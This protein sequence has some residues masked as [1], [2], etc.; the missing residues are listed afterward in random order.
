MRAEA[1]HCPQDGGFIGKCGCT[2]RNHEHSELVKGLL[3][4]A[5]TPH[6]ISV[7]DADAALEEGF[8]VTSKEGVRVGFGTPLKEHIELPSHS[9]SDQ[10][11]RK[12]CLLF[13][14]DTVQTTEPEE[15]D[16]QNRKGRNRYIKMM[17]AK[18]AMFVVTDKDGN[19]DFAKTIIPRPPAKKRAPAVDGHFG[20]DGIPSTPR[21]AVGC[22]TPANIGARAPGLDLSDRRPR[23]LPVSAGGD[24][25]TSAPGGASAKTKPP[26]GVKPRWLADEERAADLAAAI[27]RYVDAG[28][29]VPAEWT[30]ELQELIAGTE[31]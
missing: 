8:Y 14:L 29:P 11:E 22:V 25:T 7:E 4:D 1:Q 20:R 27:G 30:R 16:H 6:K 2:H 24:G 28:I 23:G 17:D 26:L 3:M 5:Q 9:V 21:P 10:K 15:R 12:R 31:P 13:A 18:K 19:A